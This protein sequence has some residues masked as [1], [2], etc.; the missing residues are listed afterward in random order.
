MCDLVLYLAFCDSEV[1]GFESKIY[2]LTVQSLNF[3][4]PVQLN[5]MWVSPWIVDPLIP[6]LSHSQMMVNGGLRFGKRNA[7]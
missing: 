4:S 7:L 6:F 3:P 5:V 2:E 1:L